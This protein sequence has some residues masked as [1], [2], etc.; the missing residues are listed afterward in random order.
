[1]AQEYRCRLRPV[2]LELAKDDDGTP[3]ADL[4]EKRIVELQAVVAAQHATAPVD[5]ASAA[6]R[7]E[8]LFTRHMV[9]INTNQ[10]AVANAISIMQSMLISSVAG[11][12]GELEAAMAELAEM[13]Q[14]LV[15][16]TVEEPDRDTPGLNV[17]HRRFQEQE[18][19][20]SPIS[21]EKEQGED[22]L[23]RD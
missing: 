23:E 18:M 9:A 19:S 5:I 15:A 7:I 13:S 12:D 22:E 16:K 8:K 10:R 20:K 4:L 11:V 21:D 17:L 3:S 1:M 14:L 2:S 6:D